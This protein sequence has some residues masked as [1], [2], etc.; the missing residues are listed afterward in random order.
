MAKRQ[1]LETL[2]TNERK[3]RGITITEPSVG[4]N[5]DEEDEPVV[6][7]LVDKQKLES[8]IVDTRAEEKQHRKELKES[9]LLSRYHPQPSPQPVNQPENEGGSSGIQPDPLLQSNIAATSVENT[10]T[11]GADKDVEGIIIM[12]EAADTE[13]KDKEVEIQ[14]EQEKGIEDE[15]NEEFNR[16]INDETQFGPQP[17]K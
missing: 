17:E 16:W 5:D 6:E 8:I 10:G 7:Q 13:E 2:Q 9:S 11:E 15:E 14:I 1:S 3:R 4:V 12:K